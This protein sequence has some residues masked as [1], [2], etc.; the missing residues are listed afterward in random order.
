MEPVNAQLVWELT[1]KGWQYVER[2]RGQAEPLQQAAGYNVVVRVAADVASVPPVPAQEVPAPTPKPEFDPGKPFFFGNKGERQRHTAEDIL[3]K[4]A[5]FQDKGISPTQGEIAKSLVPPR[6]PEAVNEQLQ[7]LRKK[8]LVA[9]LE[10]KQRA[11]IISPLGRKWLWK[12]RQTI[13]IASVVSRLV[14]D[15]KITADEL[16][17][18]KVTAN[19]EDKQAVME[20]L[21]MGEPSV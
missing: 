7:E 17:A 13:D 16:K 21:G 15:G 20:M 8:G 10:K 2:L 1:P 11:N 9:S 19:P 18:A 14:D 6:T 4:I 3:L 5:E 12:L